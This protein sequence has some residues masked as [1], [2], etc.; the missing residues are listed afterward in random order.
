M[1]ERRSLSHLHPKTAEFLVD[2]YYDGAIDRF[3][4][5]AEANPALA[6]RLNALTTYFHLPNTTLEDTGRMFNPTSPVGGE[7]ARQLIQ[8][9]VA[10]VKGF[11]SEDFRNKFS[12]D[13]IPLGKPCSVASRIRRSLASGGNTV[14][15]AQMSLDGAAPESI[16]TEVNNFSETRKVAE[17]W[18]VK[19]EAAPSSMT[20]AEERASRANSLSDPNIPI[21]EFNKAFD[22]LTFAP[23]R[24]LAQQGVLLTMA[25]ICREGNLYCR[26][27]DFG[28]VRETL[29]RKGVRIKSFSRKTE[30][31][32]KDIILRY[33]FVAKRDL[34]LAKSA[35]ES[36]QS[37][38]RFRENPVKLIAGPESSNPPSTTILSHGR[39][40]VSV[41]EILR[42]EGLNVGTRRG[43][44]IQ[45]ILNVL[46][47]PVSVYRFKTNSKIHRD[48]M[49]ALREHARRL[50]THLGR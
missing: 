37:L 35:M 43:E 42:G 12:K 16:R 22:N 44:S 10:Q 47:C 3:A 24:S 15:A 11:G 28:V 21:D 4:E 49:D 45:S 5:A 40:F 19:I 34:G 50:K 20:T 46:E 39:D 6:S 36:E 1:S 9:G 17:G 18:G 13:R 30:S 32:G 41:L 38:D 8:E 27:L 23:A 14:R 25:G 7:R 2:A 26:P 33:D 48:D 29:A 31:N